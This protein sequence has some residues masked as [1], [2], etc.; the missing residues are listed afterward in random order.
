MRRDLMERLLRVGCRL[1]LALVAV[2]LVVS[3]FEPF[4]TNWGDPWSDGN[5]MT[6]GRYF[7][8]DGFVKTAF[9]PI[10]DVGPLDA[11]SLRYTHYPPL[12]DLV[13]GVIQTL[14]GTGHLAVHRLFAILC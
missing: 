11:D 4:R 10:L 13:S 8:E 14:I 7:A 3:A 6:S 2:Y 1:C 12:P 5:A 9:T